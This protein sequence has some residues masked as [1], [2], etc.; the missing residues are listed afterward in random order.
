[1]KVYIASKYIEHR[2]INREISYVLAKNGF[3]VFLPESINCDGKTKQEMSD[4]SIECYDAID[5]SDIILVVSPFGLSVAAEV[6]YSICK[7]KK[8]ATTII[9]FRYTEKGKEKE[10]REAMLVP[11]YD[12]EISA[13]SKKT[14]EALKELIDIL[15]CLKK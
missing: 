8:S 1:M 2:Q 7:K 12:Y 13:V 10:D 11:Y 4:I 5:S 3:D 6:G 14:D 15:E 9:L